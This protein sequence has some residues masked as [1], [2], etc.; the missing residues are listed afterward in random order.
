MRHFSFPDRLISSLDT[1]L[2]TLSGQVQGTARPFPHAGQQKKE[3]PQLTE[4]EQRRC[5]QLMR[6]NHSG[7]V[8]AQALYQGQALTARNAQIAQHLRQAA[9]EENDHL[10]WCQQRL[11]QLNSH[12]SLLNPFWYLGSFSLGVL[13]GLAGDAWNLGFLSETEHQVSEHLAQ[14]LE[15]LPEH[16]EASRALIHQMQLDEL[17][18]AHMAENLGGKPLPRPIKNAMTGMAFLM[19]ATSRWL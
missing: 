2:K 5:A 7:E 4:Q 16:D 9:T 15:Q 3:E 8:C 19:K 17:A 11:K 10:Q 12:T 14:H 1:A 18:H 13:M 6:I